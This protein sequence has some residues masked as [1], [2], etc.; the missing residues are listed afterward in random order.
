MGPMAG[1]LVQLVKNLLNLLIEGSMTG[2][3]GELSNF[4]VGSVLVYVAG[5]IYYK[6]KDI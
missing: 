6:K 2:G 5:I 4:L 1:V 3:V